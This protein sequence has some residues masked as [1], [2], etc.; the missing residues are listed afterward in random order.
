MPIPAG[1]KRLLWI[2]LALLGVV[3]LIGVTTPTPPP[4][5][6]SGRTLEEHCWWI[7]Q[8]IDAGHMAL[9]S[10]QDPEWIATHQR[11]IAIAER[12]RARYGCTE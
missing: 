11:M 6:P 8:S 7:R 5:L 9:E 2:L 12:D 10:E 3:I 1:R 4:P